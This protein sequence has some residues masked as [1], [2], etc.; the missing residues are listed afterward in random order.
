LK[1]LTIYI[2]TQTAQLKE[3]KKATG[4]HGPEAT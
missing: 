4:R 1:V 3:F 2:C